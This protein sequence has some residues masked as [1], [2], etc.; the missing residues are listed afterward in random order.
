MESMEAKK[1]SYGKF[2]GRKYKEEEMT[3]RQGY[4]IAK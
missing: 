2:V 4:K 3:N 1:V